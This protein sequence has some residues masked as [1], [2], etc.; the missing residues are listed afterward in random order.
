MAAE[1]R[2]KD[3]ALDL[4][5][6]QEPWRFE[7][8]QA[9]R[10]LELIGRERKPVG[11]DYPAAQEAV[12]FRALLSRSF[13]AASIARI[14]A[15]SDDGETAA[16]PAMEVAFMGLTGP[17]GVL[18]DAYIDLLL[19]RLREHDYALR[20]FLDLFNHRTIS[21]FYRAWEKYHF[22][23]TLERARRRGGD[24]D[25]FSWCLRCLVGVGTGKQSERLPFADDVL[26]RY[27]GQ[28]AHFPRAAVVLESLLKDYLRVQVTIEQLVGR[29][30]PLE[31]EERTRLP[32]PEYPD[33]R[34][35]QLGGDLVI[36]TRVWD[37]QSSFRIRLGP[38]SYRQFDQ[39]LPGGKQLKRLRAF[40][41]MYAGPELDFEVRLILRAADVPMGRLGGRD[42]SAPRLGWNTWLCSE[43]SPSDR[44]D[45]H[46]HVSVL[47]PA[48]F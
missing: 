33:G 4:R 31:V 48:A 42:E 10:L 6:R 24:S 41:G 20:D 44:A 47:S 14:D 13:P 35:N 3:T 18:P 9:V 17:A 32:S 43:A 36:G 30:L 23:V 38:L 12:R 15:G 11:R 19:Q 22:P 21:L 39:L 25:F 2:R 5:L 45:V 1:N 37:V 40:A 27:A 28:F 26:L 46:F 8:F 29:W 16:A 7:F 34:F